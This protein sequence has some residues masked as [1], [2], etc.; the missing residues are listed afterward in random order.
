MIYLTLFYSTQ[1]K[2]LYFNNSFLEDMLHPK[3]T[4]II[5]RV[6]GYSCVFGLF[7]AF[8]ITPWEG[9]STCKDV[10]PTVKFLTWNHK[11]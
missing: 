3:A 6:G 2:Y 5:C 11:V 7:G 9:N 10:Q 4:L 1:I 8:K